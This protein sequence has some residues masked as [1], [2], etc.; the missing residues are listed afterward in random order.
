M[1]FYITDYKNRTYPLPLNPSEFKLTAERDDK[2]VTV[3]RLGEISTL[4]EEKLQSLELSF[5]IPVDIRGEHFT[6]APKAKLPRKGQSYLTWLAWIKNAKHLMRLV[7]S[8][9]KVNFQGTLSTFTYGMEDA[10]AG[11][12]KV[13]IKISQYKPHRAIKVGSSK[14]KKTAK[15]GKRRSAPP[16]KVG[17]GSKVVVNGVL[18]RTSTGT[19]AGATERNAQRKISLVAPGTKYPYHVTTLSGGARGWVSASAVKAV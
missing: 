7:I 16:K 19:G 17:R 14:K 11:D 1:I 4:G 2:T 3:V 5:T 12:Y 15:K 10:Y 13:T 8:G 9:T 6:S 18:H